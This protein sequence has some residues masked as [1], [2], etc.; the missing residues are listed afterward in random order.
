MK[1]SVRPFPAVSLAAVSALIATG[2]A[3]T[4]QTPVAAITDILTIQADAWNRG[5]VEAFMDHYWKSDELT[6]SSSGNTT[7]GWSQ[8][9]DNYKRRYPT[10]ESMGRLAF[11]NLE[12]RLLSDKAALVLGRWHLAREPDPVEGNFS[13]IFQRIDGRW[14][15]VHDHTSRAPSPDDGT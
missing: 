13:L 15:I 12:I 10:R 11:D 9:L 6:F 7:R 14:L 2:C 5:D 3:T 1:Q 8:T 4:S